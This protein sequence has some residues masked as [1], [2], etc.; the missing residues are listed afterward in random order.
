MSLKALLQEI[1]AFS[2]TLSTV[3]I[4]RGQFSPTRCAMFVSKRM[5]IY[6][7]SQ[8]VQKGAKVYLSLICAI[9]SAIMRVTENSRIASVGP[10]L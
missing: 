5:V 4:Y 1:S 6:R 10:P 8:N 7:I 2:V 3:D 9:F